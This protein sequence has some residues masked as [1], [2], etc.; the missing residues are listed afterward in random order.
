[1]I[2]DL[3]I[4]I[5][6]N[7]VVLL[8]GAI[9]KKPEL[10]KPKKTYS[11]YARTFDESSSQ[12]ID[13]AEY[14]LMNLRMLEREANEILKRD[15]YLFLNDVY[16]MLGMSRTKDGAV[17]GWVYDKENPTGDNFVDF[18]IY[19]ERNKDFVNGEKKTALLDFNVDGDILDHLN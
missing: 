1:M 2:I 5:K 3:T 14:N 10:G 19:H 11:Q 6:E 18:E 4:E 7:E 9:I 17:V 12:W 16:H 8:K 15:G 13:C